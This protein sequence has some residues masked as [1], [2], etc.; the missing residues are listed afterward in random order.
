MVNSLPD[1][2][3]NVW[4]KKMKLMANV[5][6]GA[7]LVHGVFAY[8]ATEFRPGTAPPPADCG[9][10]RSPAKTVTEDDTLIGSF[11][12]FLEKSIGLSRAEM[13]SVIAGRPVA[14][15]VKTKT[16][17]EVAI[18]GIVR[19]NAPL[20]LFIEKYRDIVV[21]ERGPGVHGGG[22]FHS[23]PVLSDVATL[24]FDD[25]EL[26]EIPKCKSGDCTI[27]LSDR[28][29]QALQQQVDWTSPRAMI[30]AQAVIRQAFVDYVDNY[31]KIGDK[32]LSVY[33]DQDKPQA[34]HE[35]L[36][37]LLQNSANVFEYDA[38]LADYLE[39]YPEEKPSDTEDIFYWQ[40]AE[41]GL[42][43]VVRASHIVIH[44]NQRENYFTYA[45][46]SKM[47]FASHY[48]RAALELKSIVPDSARPDAKSFYLVCLNR[49]LVD[50]LT[51]FKGRLIRG[52]VVQKSRKS[53][54]GYLLNTKQRIEAAQKAR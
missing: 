8:P 3:M 1:Q 48:F 38:E 12:E 19:I 15:L 5:L 14:R 23:P 33:N 28:T 43:P 13:Q 4:L 20:E 6:V 37:R 17:D 32:A 31:Q 18:F 27:K 52:T 40:K 11:R 35:G 21:F 16:K 29:M 51:G 54:A 39:K 49:S 47:L 36:H 26:K 41:F 24:Q 9:S 34:I 7:V 22:R 42:K 30:Q 46:A 44:R 10:F 53:L 25:K 45:I 50:G 2:P